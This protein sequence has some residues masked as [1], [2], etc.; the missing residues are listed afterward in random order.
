[1]RRSGVLIAVVSSITFLSLTAPAL[2]DVYPSQ[3]HWNQASVVNQDTW[4]LFRGIGGFT[5]VP[6]ANISNWR[7]GNIS[8]EWD[9]SRGH[10]HAAALDYIRQPSVGRQVR[11]YYAEYDDADTEIFNMTL[12]SAAYEYD[13]SNCHLTGFTDNLNVTHIFW[14]TILE[15]ADGPHRYWLYHESINGNGMVLTSAELFYHEEWTGGY[16]W[17]GPWWIVFLPL[18]L[19][20]IFAIS[21]TVLVRSQGKRRKV[22]RNGPQ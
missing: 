10:T 11:I 7:T 19:I 5:H 15:L 3:T 20:I 6:N 14:E 17:G 2:G 13:L 1:M 12:G 4:A 9:D 22:E 21:A 8:I 16:R 18:T